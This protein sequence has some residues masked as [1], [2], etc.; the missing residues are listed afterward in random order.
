[1]RTSTLLAALAA[2]VATASPIA[3]NN[4]KRST[5]NELTDGSCRGVTFIMARGSTETG[6]MGETVG[7][8]TC[9]ALKKIYGSDGVACQG[10]GSPYTAGIYENSLPGGTS[11]A[12]YGE[13]EKLITQA[14][15]K[16]PD[17][18][19]TCGGYSQGAAV[20]TD[21][22]QRLSSDIQSQIAGVVLYGDTRNKQDDGGIPNF[23]KDKVK[24]YC[25]SGDGVCDGA[26]IVT[27]AHLEYESKVSDAAMW[28][29][30]QVSSAGSSSNSSSN[31]TSSSPSASSS[32]SALGSLFG[33]L[34]A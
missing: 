15:T 24:V 30:T 13:A 32:A 22:I 8:A 31:T 33:G 4:L 23:S 16:C 26:L 14:H 34:R 27:A 2:A 12:A 20:M 25:N 17:T 9:K 5:E 1:M 18:V 10:V 28:L 7:P 21:G 29:Q 19:I 6:N 3:S 11:S